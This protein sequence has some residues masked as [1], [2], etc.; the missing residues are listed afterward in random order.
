MDPSGRH[1]VLSTYTFD[2][3]AEYCLNQGMAGETCVTTDAID[4]F[5]DQQHLFSHASPMRDFIFLHKPIPEFM[6]LVNNYEIS[7]HKQQEIN[8]HAMN[9][10]LFA[11]ALEQ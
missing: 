7:G 3:S 11:A 2:T 9:S 8:C 4:W 5:E 6:N 10:G 1:E